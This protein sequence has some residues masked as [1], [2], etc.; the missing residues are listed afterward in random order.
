MVGFAGWDMPVQYAGLIA[1]HEAVRSTAGVFD[2]S[3]MGEIVVSGS[4]ATEFLYYVLTNDVARLRKGRSQYTLICNE[5]GGVVDDAMLYRL[6]ETEYLLVVNAANVETASE[7]L[8][9]VVGDFEVELE[10]RSDDYCLLAVQ[11]PETEARLD[12]GCDLDLTGLRRTRIRE[13]EVFGRGVLIGRTGYTGEDGFEIFCSPEDGP[14]I[15]DELLGLD[16]MPAGLGARNTLR[17]EAGMALHGNELG[18]DITPIEA[19]LAGVVAMEKGDFVG[20]EALAAVAESGP[21]R[22]L[23]GLRTSGRGIPRDHYPVKTEHGDGVVTSGTFSPTLQG[24]I[25]MAFVPPACEI[26]D[27]VSVEIRGREWEATLVEMPFYSN[28]SRWRAK[29]S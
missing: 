26:G 24:G 7:W 29:S 28:V 17:L 8:A 19:G 25:G 9:G 27:S 21:S 1:E 2:V 13:V 15:W 4:D 10:N 18:V 11:G 5:A 23:R 20:R 6:G 14:A 12:P 16:I 22:R 3:H